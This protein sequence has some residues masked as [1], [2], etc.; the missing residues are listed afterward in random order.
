MTTP[1]ET[2]TIG[3]RGILAAVL[4]GGAARRNPRGL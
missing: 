3:R 1:P 2:G 4:V